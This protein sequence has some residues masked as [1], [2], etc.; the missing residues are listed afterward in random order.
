MVFNSDI[1]DINDDTPLNKPVKYLPKVAPDF[2]EQT[3][4]KLGNSRY[5]DEQEDFGPDDWSQGAKVKEVDRLAQY[6]RDQYDWASREVSM[7]C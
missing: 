5:P 6:W 2:L 3:R 7:C 1:I 4:A